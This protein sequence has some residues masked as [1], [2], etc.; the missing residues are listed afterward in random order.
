MESGLELYV[1]NALF[2]GIKEDDLIPLL[3]CL[4][5]QKHSYPK[6]TILFSEGEPVKYLGI[7][8]SGRIDLVYDD[9][10][11]H[12]SIIE[13]MEPGKLFCDA[14]A[15]S[16]DNR[17][18]VRVLAQEDSQ[19]LLIDIE[20]VLHTCSNSCKQ[21]HKLEENLL[22][23]LADKYIHLSRKML[24]ISEKTTHAKLLSYL[25]ERMRLTDDEPFSIPFNRQELADYLFVDRTGLSKEWNDLKRM[26]ILETRGDLFYLNIDKL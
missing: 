26:G 4:K 24:H 6:G 3:Y 8:I 7:I 9:V 2:A 15:C 1:K 11:G 22:H 20:L 18:P 16:T 25:S 23:I 5:A 19:V 13:T 17:T 21:H 14:F 10:L 12:H